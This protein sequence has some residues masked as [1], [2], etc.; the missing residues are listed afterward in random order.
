MAQSQTVPV[1]NLTDG[2]ITKTLLL[3]AIPT[4]L[5]N[6]LQSLNGSINTIWVGRFLGEN[7]LAATANANIISFLLFSL[8]F[9]FGMAATVMV[10]QNIGRKDINEARRAFGAAIGFCLV[11]SI[12][13]AVLGLLFSSDI[14]YLLKT[15]D[16]AFLLAEQY[17][18]VIFIANPANLLMLMVMMGLRGSGDSITP[19]IFMVVNVVLDIIFNPLFILG[20][21]I[22]PKMGI[23]GAA[24]SSAVSGYSALISMLIYIY[25]KNLPLRL[26]GRELLYIWPHFNLMRYIVLKGFPMSLQMMIIASAGLVMIGLVNHE[27]VLT[28]AAYNIVQQLWTYL[29]MPSMAVGAAVS[30]MAAQ[31]IGAGRWGRVDK[32]TKIGCIATFIITCLLLGLLL[33]FDRPVIVLFLG[34]QNET[35]EYARHIQFLAS[36][37]FLFFGVSMVLYSTVR[38]NGAVLVPLFCL[39]IAMYPVR[40]GFYYLSYHSIGA[41]AIWLSFPI[42]AL[43]SLIMAACYYK[44]GLW[45]KTRLINTQPN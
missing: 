2:P 44:S 29:Q 32:I 19:L 20:I 26:K 37:S 18:R 5:S 38:A 45:K 16:D 12:C 36:W 8:V 27:G 43:A 34:A 10:G 21:W 6:I 39:F 28:I 33:I 30:A 11:L 14:L 13:I 4:L 23:A 35:V 17:L 42:G 41:N 22:F 1:N 31:N 9:G 40:L 25:V 3:F 24:V 7:A 15:P